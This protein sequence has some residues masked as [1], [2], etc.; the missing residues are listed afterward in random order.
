M[1]ARTHARTH[2][3]IHTYIHTYITLH[4]ITLHC[5]TLH[6]ITLH[7]ITLHTYIHVYIYIYI[8][9][10]TYIYTHIHRWLYAYIIVLK[11]YSCY[12]CIRWSADR[13]CCG[14]SPDEET[15]NSEFEPNR[16]IISLKT[17]KFIQAD[18][19]VKKR[20]IQVWENEEIRNY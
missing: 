7:Y 16:L 14:R 11:H 2:A 12:S 9:V 6:Y 10:Y 20:F 15:R 3:G 18:S 1:H 19:Q 5:I 8:Y 4:Y 17:C 13:I